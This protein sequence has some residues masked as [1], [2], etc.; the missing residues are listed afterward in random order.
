MREEKIIFGRERYNSP[1]SATITSQPYDRIFNFSAGPCTL[2]V[3]VLEEARD[4]LMNWN[5]FGA[6]VLEM[7][8][9][10]KAFESI[11]ADA[12]ADLRELMGIPENYKVL[13]LQGGASMQFTMLPMNLR[14]EGSSADYV[15]TGAWGKKAVEAA[16]LQGGRSSVIHDGKASNYN[17]TPKL[18]ELS[19]NADAAY[20]HFTSNETIQGVDFLHDPEADGKLWICDMSSNILSRKVDVSRYGM[21]YAGAQKNMGPA[22][23]T[24]VVL[25]EDLLERIPAGLPPMLDYKLMV[26]NNSLY[27]TPPCWSIYMCGLMYKWMKRNGGLAAMEAQNEAKAKL[28]Y[29]A[30]DSTDFYKGH[31]EA[32]SRSRMNITFTLPTEELGKELV[33]QAKGMGMIELNGHRSVGGCRASVYNAFPVEGCQVLADFMR[34]FA[35]KNG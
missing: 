11:L 5:G 10:S 18:S 17:T 6:S 13:F 14:A 9:R 24:L 19:G 33:S 8:H 32:G 30:I 26:E 15:V 2:P 3:E 23:A 12:I 34:D 16:N 7:S 4:G 1:M 20:T 29:D 21:I 31:A 22:G 25:R 35:A 27:N 28:I